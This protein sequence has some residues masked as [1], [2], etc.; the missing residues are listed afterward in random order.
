MKLYRPMGGLFLFFASC[1][2]H[3]EKAGATAPATCV[4]Q[5]N[6][7]IAT[8]VPIKQ[9]ISFMIADLKFD[10]K[11]VKIC[12]FGEGTRSRFKGYDYLYGKGLIWERFWKVLDGYH[13][14]KWYVDFNL[15]PAND[16]E[17]LYEEASLESF[18]QRSE[19]KCFSSLGDLLVSRRFERAAENSRSAGGVFGM[20]MVR[21]YDASVGMIEA[22]RKHYKNLLVLNAAVAPFV[23]NKYTTDVL[24]KD[25]ALQKFRP[26]ALLCR[27]AYTA[28]LASSIKKKMP[29]THYV[30]KPLDAFK[31][32]G[33][34]MVE[35]ANLD[36]TL[37]T[38]LD[39]NSHKPKDF[40]VHYNGYS[41]T[42]KTYSYWA[43]YNEPYFIVEELSHSK[44]L[45]FDG[46]RYDPT[47]RAVFVLHHQGG[48][49]KID[50]LAA[51]WKLPLKSLDEPGTLTEKYKSVG[52]IP[53]D[54]TPEERKILYAQLDKLLLPLYR[55]MIN[56]INTKTKLSV[57]LQA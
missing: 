45:T 7:K 6:R 29:A 12:E 31:G 46:K 11:Q 33:I 15:L 30:I 52:I 35:A 9:D 44:I 13:F 19:A 8:M 37:R 14:P 32:C 21:H 56:I 51:Y 48:I 54:T 38:I 40:T 36:Q 27:R 53:I 17:E 10:G 34:V 4:D 2:M 55:K 1:F 23:N 49:E 20:L 26:Q 3:V 5:L 57:P 43:T 18:L 22:L 47:L 42:D 28:G 41:Y 50:Y 25:E 24:F 39:K 16:L